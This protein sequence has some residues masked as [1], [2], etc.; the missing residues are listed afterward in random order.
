M[1]NTIG[2]CTYLLVYVDDVLVVGNNA[3]EIRRVKEHLNEKFS[4][5]DLGYVKYFLGV[6][7]IKTDNGLFLNQRKYI[8][9]ILSDASMS[10]CKP[11]NVHMSTGTNLSD[12]Q[13]ELYGDLGQ[14][15]RLVEDFYTRISP[16]MT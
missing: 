2:I 15:R 6:E 4:I 8:L 13:D 11:T 3:D 9:D 10:H 14:Y 1:K 5:K 16:D 12:N 7:I